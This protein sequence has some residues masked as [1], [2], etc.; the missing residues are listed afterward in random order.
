MCNYKR[1]FEGTPGGV[2]SRDNSVESSGTSAQVP[3]NRSYSTLAA[4]AD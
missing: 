2:M 1:V 4:A 3:L